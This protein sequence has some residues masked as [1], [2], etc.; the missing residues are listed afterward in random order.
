MISV[1]VITKNES[2]RLKVCLESVKWADEI[3][4]ADN[5]STDDTLEIAKR[6]TD[7]I[8]VFKDQDF[9]ELRNKAFEK[10][11]GDWVLY[12]DADER[13]LEP[14]KE[15]ILSLMLYHAGISF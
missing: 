5:G 2:E 9:A 14:L 10:T 11:S 8:I 3:V 1:V 6:Y 15:E 12:V 13:V 4:V 7:K